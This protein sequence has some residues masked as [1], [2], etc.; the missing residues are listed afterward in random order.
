MAENDAKNAWVRRVL[1]VE[2]GMKTAEAS[3]TDPPSVGLD[4]LLPLW[5]DA[6]E[7]IDRGIDQLQRAL[8]STNDSD[9]VQ[10]AEYGLNGATSGQMTRLMVAIRDI[11]SGVTPEARAKVADAV[12][13]FRGFLAGSPIVTLLEENPFGVAIP[14][15]ATLGS[16]LDQID[17]AIAA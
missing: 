9:L 10:I 17:R 12:E 3:T 14:L 15:R 1:G 16:A 4:K 11:G 13:G 2:I 5:M 8:M 7:T 6:K